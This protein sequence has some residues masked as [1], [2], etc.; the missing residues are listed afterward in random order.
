MRKNFELKEISGALTLIMTLGLFLSDGAAMAQSRGI[1][2]PYSTVGFGLGT[3]N[4]YGDFA[5]YRRPVASTFNMMRWSVAGNYT[6]HFTPRLAARASFTYARIAGDDYIMNKSSK[7]ETNIFYARNL[8][9]RNDLK[10][11]SVQGIYKLTPDNRSYDRRPQF[12]AYLFAGI[13]V[14]AHNP[15]AMVPDEEDWNRT[16][17]AGTVYPGSGEWVKLQPLGTE[18]QGN[19]GYKDKYSLVTFAI[20]VGVGVR[21]KINSRFDVSAEL[22]FRKTFTDYL[23]DAHGAYAD[24][25][26]FANDPLALAMSN[27]SQERVAVRKGAVR[28]ESLKKFV[29]ANY[30]G[31]APDGDPYA[32]MINQGFARPGSDRGNSPT[33]TDNYLIGQIQLHYILPTQIKC[34]PLK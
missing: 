27:R 16:Q 5:P 34:P 19:E 13:A 22:G 23:D 26:L 9:F 32:E 18:G 12:S 25:A 24:P 10:E 1:F 4:Y 33:Y 14:T 31:A 20:P 30:V 11:F 6:R 15:K 7:H 17:P 21:Y 3:S 29:Q 28:T 2:I 8:H